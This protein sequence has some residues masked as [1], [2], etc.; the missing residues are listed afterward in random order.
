MYSL[1]NAHKVLLALLSSALLCSSIIMYADSH[2]YVIVMYCHIVYYREVGNAFT[3]VTQISEK[4]PRYKTPIFS[5]FI[6][7]LFRTLLDI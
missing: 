4:K 3:K 2:D 7:I 1:K 5:K 6:D